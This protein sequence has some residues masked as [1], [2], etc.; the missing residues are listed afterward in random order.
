MLWDNYE[1]KKLKNDEKRK[2]PVNYARR[3]LIG[4]TI[5]AIFAL[6]VLLD[7]LFV[8]N[9]NPTRDYLREH[10]VPAMAVITEKAAQYTQCGC[11]HTIHYQFMTTDSAGAFVGAYEGSAEV[12][13]AAYDVLETGSQV[14]ILYSPA[15]PNQSDLKAAV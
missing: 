6:G 7:V 9:S 1:P 12:D 11:T 13:K 8:F 15:N 14:E 5:L 3:V 2:E 4:L 10:G